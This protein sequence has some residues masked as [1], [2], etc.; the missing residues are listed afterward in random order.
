MYTLIKVLIQIDYRNFVI[1]AQ[2]IDHVSKRKAILT[3]KSV[4]LIVIL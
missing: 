3:L 4:K 2:F 1:N